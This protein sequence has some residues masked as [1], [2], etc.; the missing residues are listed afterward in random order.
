MSE[1]VLIIDGLN[2][3]YR[4]VLTFGKPKEDEGKVDYTVVYNCF[5]NL[6]P[7]IEEMKP[8]KCFFVLEGN[9]QFRKD[10]FPDY[11]KNRIV[12][13]GSDKEKSRNNILRQAD[14][15]YDLVSLLPITLVR[16]E[17]YE[18]DDTIYALANNL[19]E[20]EVVIVSSDSDLIQILQSLSGYNVKLFH[21]GKKTYI[22]APEYSYLAWKCIA[23]DKRTDNIP[24]ITSANKAEK[25]ARDPEALKQFLESEENKANFLLN[26]QLIGLQ[27]VADSDLVF[28][29]P[30]VDFD[31]LFAEFARLEFASLLKDPYRE[32][33]IRTFKEHLK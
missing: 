11:K 21:P 23:G 1:R 10:L 28:T 4:G 8:T 30:T 12:K 29:P 6:R 31:K 5:R 19:K 15:I 14:I 17:A 13:T 16:A 9:P 22:E 20:E 3:I 32:R 26:K 25:I 27:L 2:W 24:G 33:F 7:L 18:A